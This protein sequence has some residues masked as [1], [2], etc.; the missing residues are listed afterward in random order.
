MI[1]TLLIR[2]FFSDGKTGRGISFRRVGVGEKKEAVL[3][4]CAWWLGM[5]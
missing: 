3:G 2:P 5:G 4:L 1:S